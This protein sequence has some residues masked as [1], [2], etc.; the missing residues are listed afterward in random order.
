MIRP[1]AYKFQIRPNG[2]QV[3]KMKQFVGCCRY[4]YNRALA[5][6]NEAYEADHSVHFNYFEIANK[7]PLWKAELSW[8]KECNAQIL[9]QSLKNLA[10]AFTNFFEKRANYPKFK[11]KGDRDSA[12]FPQGVKLDEANNRV[13]LPKIGWMRYRNSQ[14]VLG[15]I[16]NVIIS[17]KC[18]KWYMSIQTERE[19]VTPTPK[20]GEVGIDLGV[21]RPVT[22]STGKYFEPIDTYKKIRGRI[23]KLQQQLKNKT[24]FSKNWKRLQSRINKLYH[25]SANIRKNY[26]HQITSQISKNHAIVYV[27]DLQ[28]ENMTK[29]AK[30][31]VENPGK[32][33][34]AKSGLNRAILD[35][36]W[37]EF[38]RQLDYKLLWNGGY[39]IAVPPQNTSRTCPMCG[40]VSKEN[41]Q[42]QA[43]FVC[44]CCGFSENADVEGAMNV[45][46]RGQLQLA[47]EK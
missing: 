17:Q 4:V 16:K 34:K 45:L 46:K 41:R 40:H 14:C 18:G 24:K 29:S 32:N 20:G 6:H 42:T 19:V 36:G 43:K 21:V 31:T 13:Y 28:V 44:V 3:R 9:Q 12:R 5:E 23:A 37:G 2:E 15:T 39:L 33:V 30:G 38:R 26:L 11:C 7:L 10:Q 25:K 1:Q 35:Q 22:L 47:A 8:L 27:E